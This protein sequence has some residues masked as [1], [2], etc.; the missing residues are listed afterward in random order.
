MCSKYL[1]KSEIILPGVFV[2]FKCPSL[3]LVTP[4]KKQQ[5]RETLFTVIKFSNSQK[6]V[7]IYGSS[8]GNSLAWKEVLSVHPQSFLRG[9]RKMALKS[10]KVRIHAGRGTPLKT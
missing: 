7:M 8:I 6:K 4:R 9:S 5:K 1:L 3:P 10:E 2:F